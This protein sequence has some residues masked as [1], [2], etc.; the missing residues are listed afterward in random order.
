MAARPQNGIIGFFPQ[1]SSSGSAMSITATPFAQGNF[2]LRF[3]PPAPVRSPDAWQKLIGEKPIGARLEPLPEHRTNW[4]ALATSTF[5]QLAI[6]VALFLLQ[7]FIPQSIITKVEYAV[8]P[9][10]G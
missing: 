6:V 5:S 10:T 2:D 3:R 9:L 4:R 7:M 8:M 1:E